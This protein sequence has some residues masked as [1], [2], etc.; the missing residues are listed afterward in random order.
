MKQM[1]SFLE[2]S[3]VYVR[4]IKGSNNDSRRSYNDDDYKQQIFDQQDEANE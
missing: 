3:K 1:E 2:L 4:R